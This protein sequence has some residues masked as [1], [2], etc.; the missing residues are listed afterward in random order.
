[1]ALVA[2]MYN[3]YKFYNNLISNLFF[4]EWHI[5]SAKLFPEIAHL[6][7]AKPSV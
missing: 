7:G 6:L 2:T 4:T 3:A 5:L 1:M